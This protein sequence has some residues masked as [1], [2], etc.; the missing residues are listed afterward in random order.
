MAS[1]QSEMIYDE[2]STTREN[3][4]LAQMTAI[5]ELLENLKKTP[6]EVIDDF[7]SIRKYCECRLLNRYIRFTRR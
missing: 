2:S 6:E 4:V 5:P 1:F 3:A 7:E